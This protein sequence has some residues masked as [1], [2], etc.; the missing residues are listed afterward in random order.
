[1][2]DCFGTA[3]Y[4]LTMQ[5]KVLLDQSYTHWR[6]QITAQQDWKCQDITQLGRAN[7]HSTLIIKRIVQS[8]PTAKPLEFGV[9]KSLSKKEDFFSFSSS[10]PSDVLLLF[11]LINYY[12][13]LLGGTLRNYQKDNLKEANKLRICL[14][15]TTDHGNHSCHVSSFPRV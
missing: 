10:K 1:M 7:S 9:E 13:C 12:P 15:T 6:H 4:Y 14:G 11:R 2:E 5:Y 8:K 3:T